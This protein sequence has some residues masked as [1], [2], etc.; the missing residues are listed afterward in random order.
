MD[1]L[2]IG[3]DLLANQAGNNA[4]TNDVSNILGGLIGDGDSMD[5]GSL[6]KKMQDSGDLG[7]I[8]ASWLGDGDNAAIDPSQLA[9]VLDSGKL[10]QAASALG[11]DLDS[12]LPMLATI[13]PQMVDKSSRGGN[14]LESLDDMGGL[15]N[16]AKNLFD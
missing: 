6:V 13:I 1:L 7:S 10:Q 15:A 9:G 5:I 16:M 14:L 12:L 11:L 8:V 2:Q 4:S 3:A